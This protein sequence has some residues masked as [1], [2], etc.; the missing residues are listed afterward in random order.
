[1]AAEKVAGF[2]CLK[3]DMGYCALKKRDGETAGGGE[4]RASLLR[5]ARKAIPRKCVLITAPGPRNASA[6]LRS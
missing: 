3:D 1:M 6:W 5:S 4:N 2:R